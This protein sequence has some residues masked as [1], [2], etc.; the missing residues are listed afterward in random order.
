MTQPHFVTAHIMLVLDQVS[1]QIPRSIMTNPLLMTV[2]RT[3]SSFLFT[4]DT[5]VVLSSQ[6]P[7]LTSQPTCVFL[8]LLLLVRQPRRPSSS[9]CETI[10]PTARWKL[11]SWQ[12]G[13]AMWWFSCLHIDQSSMPLSRPG[14]L[15]RTLLHA[16]TVLRWHLL[17]CLVSLSVALWRSPSPLGHRLTRKWRRLRCSNFLPCWKKGNDRRS[18]AKNTQT[19]FSTLEHL[20][21]L[22]TAQT[23]VQRV[24]MGVT[25]AKKKSYIIWRMAW[26]VV[27]LTLCQNRL[28][29]QLLRIW[30]QQLCCSASWRS[31]LV[32]LWA[33]RTSWSFTPC[34]DLP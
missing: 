26:V 11:R 4:S 10:R 34:Q 13:M 29:T 16:T 30:R 24:T 28:R 12:G 19:W 2:H 20:R 6:M 17:T 33:T 1:L 32:G 27:T 18:F 22:M 15:P 8:F 21:L 25:M 5:D 23:A 31:E 9:F 14:Q 7:T 3:L